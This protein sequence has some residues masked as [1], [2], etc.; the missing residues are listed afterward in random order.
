MS[1]TLST[2]TMALPNVANMSPDATRRTPAW[3]RRT[4]V[5]WLSQPE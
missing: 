3:S 4:I 2:L 1:T 5:A